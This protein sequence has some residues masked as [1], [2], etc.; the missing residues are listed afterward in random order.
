MLAYLEPGSGGAMIGGA[1]IALV[2]PIAIVV[3]VIW[4][5]L[6]AI[7][8]VRQAVDRNTRTLEQQTQLLVL[9]AR[10]QGIIRPDERDPASVE[11]RPGPPPGWGDTR[12]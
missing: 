12:S 10:R 6:R 4:L 3:F 1:L 5:F 2:L 11:P 8:A 9:I 7:G